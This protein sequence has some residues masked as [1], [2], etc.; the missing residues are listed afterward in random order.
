M[1]NALLQTKVKQRINKLDSADADNLF[2]WQIQEAF[3][4]AQREWVR[5]QVE[6]INQKREGRE[7]SSMKMADLQN[8]LVTWTDTFID[9]Q[10]YFESCDFPE[11]YLIFSRI[12]AYAVSPD[13]CCPD[14]R[15][16]IYQAQESDVD[17]LL[18]D[19]TRNPNYSWGETFSTLF[20][21]KVRIYTDSKFAISKPQVIYYRKPVT[22]QFL[23]CTDTETGDISVED[24]ECEFTDGVTELIIDEAAKIIAADLA[25][26][27][28]SQRLSQ[29]E[30]HNT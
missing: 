8:L 20:G 14:R 16:V 21:N 3:N 13:G 5:R 2:C 12:S 17:I 22:V 28:N 23:G 11:D 10:L 30:E 7:S 19:N 27:Q 24:I 6:G 15:L 4:K 26:F 1:N 25:D 18:K 9:K 29:E